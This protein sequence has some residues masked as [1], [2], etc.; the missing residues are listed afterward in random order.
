MN[1]TA[2]VDRLR[3]DRAALHQR[4]GVRSLALFGSYARDAARPDS[5][6][7]LLVDF[8]STPSLRAYADLKEHLE[9]LLGYPVDLITR[10]ALRRELR[11]RIEAEAIDVA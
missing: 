6:V 2:L 8:Q 3:N 7:D 1:R 4:Y 11:A 9:G 5:D 10:Q